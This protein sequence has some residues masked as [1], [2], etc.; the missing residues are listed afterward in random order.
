M[1]VT[2]LKKERNDLKSQIHN[3]SKRVTSGIDR[4]A[5]ATV[6]DT[7]WHDLERLYEDFLRVNGEY[8][9]LVSN[10]PQLSEHKVV[11]GL[12]LM[13]CLSRCVAVY[14]VHYFLF[15]YTTLFGTLLSFRALGTLLWECFSKVNSN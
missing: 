6:I 2:E 10:D 4:D 14:L 9:S 13:Q 8:E 1:S 5:R 7:S 12:D 11:K 3:L 15:W